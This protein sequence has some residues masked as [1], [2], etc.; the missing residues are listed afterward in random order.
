MIPI[1]IVARISKL[2]LQHFVVFLTIII[3]IQ[4]T[5]TF[6]FISIEFSNIWVIKVVKEDI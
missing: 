1:N 5:S 6:S 2:E 3:N 4:Y